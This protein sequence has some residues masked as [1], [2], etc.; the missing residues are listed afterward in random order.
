MSLEER[1][2][3]VAESGASA[4]HRIVKT[5]TPK[6]L[7]FFSLPP[8]RRRRTRDRLGSPGGTARSRRDCAS[9]KRNR[10]DVVARE[11][12]LQDN[13]M[14]VNDGVISL[15]LLR[16]TGRERERAKERKGSECASE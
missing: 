2:A 4:R 9:D 12:A 16:E 5:R 6:L 11:N 7:R 1:F 10:S 8:L 15:R 14:Y 13:C 3:S